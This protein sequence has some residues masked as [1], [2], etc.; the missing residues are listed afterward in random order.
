MD[1]ATPR[2]LRP[3][4]LRPGD[5]VPRVHVKRLA[6]A[7]LL[8]LA[9][10]GCTGGP[11]ASADTVA[12]KGR[13]DGSHCHAGFTDGTLVA[14]AIGVGMLRDEDGRIVDIYWPDGFTGRRAGTEIDIL[15]GSGRVVAR[16]GQRY[17]LLGGGDG[18]VVLVCAEGI[19]PPP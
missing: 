16:T 1:R 4:A 6:L 11:S 5:T 15:D 17:K 19:L 2:L 3:K 14:Q 13:I 8:I 10:A 12:L 9:A 7:M 18:G